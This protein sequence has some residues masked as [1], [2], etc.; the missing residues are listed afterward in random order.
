MSQYLQ[1]LLAARR[2]AQATRVIPELCHRRPPHMM[3]VAP[4]AQLRRLLA[5][6]ASMKL[7][8]RVANCTIAGDFRFAVTPLTIPL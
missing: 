3:R 4:I 1:P 2:P 5:S 6:S 7:V 8:S